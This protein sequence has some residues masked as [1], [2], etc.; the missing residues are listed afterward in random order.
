MGD[1]ADDI[2]DGLFC[3]Y[4]GEYLEEAVGYPRSCSGCED[5][6]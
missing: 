6:D 3:Q 5:E 4:C 1:M 2:I